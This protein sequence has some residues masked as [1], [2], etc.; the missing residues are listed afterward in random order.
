LLA[1]KDYFPNQL[2]GGQKQLVAILR[3]LINEPRFLLAD[4]PTG[5]LDEKTASIVIKILCRYQKKIGMGLIVCSHDPNL[6]ESLDKI[7]HLE[8]GALSF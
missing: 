6:F 4:E 3:A 7:I 1:Y 5:N 2:S 8:N